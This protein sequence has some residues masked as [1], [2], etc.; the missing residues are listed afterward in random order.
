MSEILGRI[1]IG[2]QCCDFVIQ[3]RLIISG[4][5]IVWRKFRS[6]DLFVA[7]F[8]SLIEVFTYYLALCEERSQIQLSQQNFFLCNF[9]RA[10]KKECCQIL[11]YTTRCKLYPRALYAHRTGVTHLCHTDTTKFGIYSETAD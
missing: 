4:N 2:R 1:I 9:V 11:A 10:I 3:S 6:F 7:I 5:T 8:I